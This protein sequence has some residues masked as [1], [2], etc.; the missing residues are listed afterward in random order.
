[1]GVTGVDPR[2][3]HA[4]GRPQVS[5][6]FGDLWSAVSA[7]SETRAERW[8]KACHPAE[9]KSGKV[10][11]P[12]TEAY[13][14]EKLQ[15]DI[16]QKVPAWS[17]DGSMIAYWS[18]LEANDRRPGLPRDVWV[19]RADGTDHRRLIAG[20]DPGWSPDGRTIV[21][22]RMRAGVGPE[23]AVIRPDGTHAGIVRRVNPVRPL[24][25]SWGRDER[26]R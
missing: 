11:R 9:A 16:E 13:R 17:P 19:M 20:D 4:P 22:S 1:M 12:L 10:L 15:A 24:Q 2:G 25:S 3:R 26:V 7:G 8:R 18:G 6:G 5:P 21:F 23:L 14:D